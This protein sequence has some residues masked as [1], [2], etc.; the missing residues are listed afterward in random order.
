MH[1]CYVNDV[2]RSAF[3]EITSS[4][5]RLEQRRIKNGSAYCLLGGAGSCIFN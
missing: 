4:G 1:R 3:P 2:L 5:M